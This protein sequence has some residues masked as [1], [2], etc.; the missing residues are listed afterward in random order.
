MRFEQLPERMQNE[1]V[2]AY[3][4]LLSRKK[5][6][7]AF[8]R[9]FDLAASGVMLILLS[10][11]FAYI[12][13]RIKM[14]T[15]GPVFFRQTRYTTGMRPFRIYKFRS[16]VD[17]AESRGPLVTVENDGR[18]TRTGAWLRR[19]RLDETP[20][21]IN[22]FLGDMSFVGTRP[23]VGKYVERYTDE[24]LATLLMPAGVTSLASI[25]FR[26]EA[27]LLENAEDADEVYV[28]EILPRK[29]RYNLEYIRNFSFFSDIKLMLSTVK[30]VSEDRG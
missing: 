26:D 20:Q 18:I 1:T 30:A 25:K 10:P 24:M 3:Y 13:L 16:M 8:K 22:V 11:V 17:R 14:D 15:P 19:T 21:L 12:A 9:A 2:R 6:A 7:L 28:N 5:A 4:D 29:M 23:E 27:A